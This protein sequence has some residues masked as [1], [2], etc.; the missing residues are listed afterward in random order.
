M[1]H[2]LSTH[3]VGTKVTFQRNGKEITG[4]VSKEWQLHVTVQTPE[5]KKYQVLKAEL[6][7]PEKVTFSE[8]ETDK[9]G[10]KPKN[11]DKPRVKLGG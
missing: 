11:P 6:T 5:K 8:P 9:P 10:T 7:D 4:K 2:P 3:P 1:T